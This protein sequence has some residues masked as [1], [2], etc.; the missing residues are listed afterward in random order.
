MPRQ[1]SFTGRQSD[2]EGPAFAPTTQSAIGN[3][4]LDVQALRK[5]WRRHAAE[6]ARESKRPI[7]PELPHRSEPAEDQH[8]SFHSLMQ[9]VP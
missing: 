3:I 5:N 6:L 9:D 4:G 2:V 7:A 1:Q 8:E